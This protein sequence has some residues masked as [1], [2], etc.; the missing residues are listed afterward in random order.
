MTVG[1]NPL[2]YGGANGETG[3]IC[4]LDSCVQVFVTVSLD[5]VCRCKFNS[6]I[7]Q[8]LVLNYR[9]LTHPADALFAKLG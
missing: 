8:M 2:G 4:M 7:D 9:D 1:L 6:I 5:S 3:T